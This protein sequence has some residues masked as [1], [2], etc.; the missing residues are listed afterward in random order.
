MSKISLFY[1]FSHSSPSPLGQNSYYFALTCS[2]R[3]KN[4][5]F[6]Q[7]LFAGVEHSFQS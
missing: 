2:Y 7:H 5:S 4:P 1:Y 3:E 6:E